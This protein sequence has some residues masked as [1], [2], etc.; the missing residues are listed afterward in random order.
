VEET[1]K[2]GVMGLKR[3]VEQAHK[4]PSWERVIAC[5]VQPWSET[6]IVEESVTFTLLYTG[7]A[8]MLFAW[9]W[10]YLSFTPSILESYSRP[11]L[12]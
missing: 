11:G 2:T 5:H 9:V 7:L 10:V 3:R 12:L 4:Q 1:S 6:V 8:S